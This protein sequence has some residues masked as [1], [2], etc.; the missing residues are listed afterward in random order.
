MKMI[1]KIRHTT[2]PMNQKVI[3][4][5]LYTYLSMHVQQNKVLFSDQI[6]VHK[7][8]I[9]QVQSIRLVNKHCQESNQTNRTNF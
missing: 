8:R 6:Q 5:P 7:R 2:M 1:P 3:L 4:K 9:F